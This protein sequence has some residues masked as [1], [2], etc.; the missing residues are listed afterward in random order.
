MEFSK[1]E[2]ALNAAKN[3]P[4][5]EAAKDAVKIAADAERAKLEAEQNTILAKIGYI[6][7]NEKNLLELA[8]INR[9]SLIPM[10]TENDEKQ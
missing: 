3:L 10:P 4:A 2:K 7:R 9:H 8:E 5:L 6:N 1:L